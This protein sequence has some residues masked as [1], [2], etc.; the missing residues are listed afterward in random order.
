IKLS[1]L[2]DNFDEQILS[3]IEKT[4]NS[5]IRGMILVAIIQGVLAGIG[6]TLSKN[7]IEAHGGYL[8]YTNLDNRTQFV[9]CLLM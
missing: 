3:K 4:I 6:L 9:I 5:V 7:I 8:S 1:P 2:S